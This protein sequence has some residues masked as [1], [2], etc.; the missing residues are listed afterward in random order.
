VSIPAGITIFGKITGF[1]LTSG[2]VIAYYA[3]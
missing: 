3:V 1:Q 2:S